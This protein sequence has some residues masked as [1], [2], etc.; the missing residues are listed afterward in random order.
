MCDCVGKAAQDNAAADDGSADDGQVSY[1]P[2]GV[3]KYTEMLAA[4]GNELGAKQ[5]NS[6]QSDGQAKNRPSEALQE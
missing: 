1:G 6:E 5:Q 3:G 4:L 2:K